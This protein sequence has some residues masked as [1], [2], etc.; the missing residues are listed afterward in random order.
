MSIYVQEYRQGRAHPGDVMEVNDNPYGPWYGILA[1]ES[2]EG[3]CQ[4]IDI[5]GGGK[6][7]RL[8]SD[9]QICTTLD[10]TTICCSRSTC[11]VCSKTG[12][13]LHD[14]GARRAAMLCRDC[15]R[16]RVVASAPV[17]HEF[18]QMALL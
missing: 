15:A 4:L 5:R 10:D 12:A 18:E 13:S 1:S 7:I 11:I 9:C 3:L 17:K 14:I 6:Y 2:L 16:E 8:R